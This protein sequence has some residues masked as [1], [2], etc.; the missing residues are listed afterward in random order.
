[1]ALGKLLAHATMLTGFVEGPER[2][3]R[4]IVGRMV[5]LIDCQRLLPIWLAFKLLQSLRAFLGR[6]GDPRLAAGDT[7]RT[8]T[9]D[10]GTCW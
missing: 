1:M 2:A 8:W 10:S 5:N 9:L 3:H 4:L 6:I 7:N